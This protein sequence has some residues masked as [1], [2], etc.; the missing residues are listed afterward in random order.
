MATQHDGLELVRSEYYRRPA[1]LNR[2]EEQTASA[3]RG[4]FGMMLTDLLV[5]SNE[6]L[7]SHQPWCHC[8]LS[9]ALPL[10]VSDDK[11]LS[12]I[13]L[14]GLECSIYLLTSPS[15]RTPRG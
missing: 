2:S 7:K 9:F 6:W 13:F 5:S 14:R 11:L 3:V 4:A 8:T 15:D 12:C 1:P 10:A